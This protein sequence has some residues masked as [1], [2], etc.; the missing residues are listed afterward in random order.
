M[1]E[2]IKELNPDLLQSQPLK[3]LNYI[4]NPKLELLSYAY[5]FLKQSLELR[6]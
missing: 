1:F 6:K 5:D 4:L 3:K 2:K